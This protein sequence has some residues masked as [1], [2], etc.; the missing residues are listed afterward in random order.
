MAFS[1]HDNPSSAPLRRPSHGPHAEQE[2]HMMTQTESSFDVHE[3]HRHFQ[4]CRRYF[5]DHSQHSPCLQAVAAYMNILL[6]YQRH[7]NPIPAYSPPRST[8]A[9]SGN[10]T[11]ST[12][13]PK[14]DNRYGESVS[15]V[16]Y[17]RRLVVTGFDTEAMLQTFFGDDWA[18]GIGK[19]HESERRNYLFAAKSG[20]WLE[21]K[22]S[23]EPSPNETIPHMMPIRSPM[24]NEI[25]AAEEKW[26][27]WLAMQDWMV[28]P[29]APPSEA[30]RS[31]LEMDP[32]E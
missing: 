10:S 23:Y 19:L 5:L 31:H 18:K 28:G 14:P 9:H 15:L 17:I 26:S 6:P 2:E 21:V 29:R 30:M 7:P 4:N 20:S 3:W 24:E 27:D 13:S 22:A 11:P 12:L 8:A 25:R 1:N 16:P 32:M